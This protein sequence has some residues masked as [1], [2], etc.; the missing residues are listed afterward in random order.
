MPERKAAIEVTVDCIPGMGPIRTRALRKAGW[1]TME[2][3]RKATLADL[4]AVPGI[5]EIKARQILDYLAGAEA[6]N[7]PGRL[8]AFRNGVRAPSTTKAGWAMT[9]PGSRGKTERGKGTLWIVRRYLLQIRREARCELSRSLGHA[10]PG[11]SRA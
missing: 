9:Y 8:R 2:R 11:R 10:H 3:L 1:E 6:A 5:T 4:I 7:G